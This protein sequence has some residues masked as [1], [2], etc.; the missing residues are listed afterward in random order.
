MKKSDLEFVNAANKIRNRVAV[1]DYYF[2]KLPQDLRSL[3]FMVSDLETLRQI[4]MVKKS[5]DNAIE[6]GESFKTWRDNLDLEVLESLSQA[7]LETV[8]RTNVAS[9][10]NQSTRYNAYTS[11][12]TPYLMY[13]AVGDDN[14]RPEHMKLD[15]TIKRADSDFWD[16]YTPPLGY[17]CRCSTIPLSKSEAENRGIS[18]KSNSSFPN[19]EFGKSKMGDML[20]QVSKET[21][22]AIDNMP[23]SALKEK[24]KSAQDNIS[25]LVDIWW[26]KE[27]NNFE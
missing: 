9:V 22:K 7:R 24:F 23:S 10:Y 14:T 15:G 6:Q 4:E 8:Y 25:S 3:S 11:D 26:Q 16:T 17:N 5:L 13:S 20:T 27:K 1:K 12:V 19:P 2:E 18:R 21:T